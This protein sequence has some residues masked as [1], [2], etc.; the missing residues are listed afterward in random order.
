MYSTPCRGKWNSVGARLKTNRRKPGSGQ[1]AAGLRV[2]AAS[3]QVW[4][5][6]G[7]AQPIEQT[8]ERRMYSR[9][10]PRCNR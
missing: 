5:C 3:R 1:R 4:G 7:A 9:P 6:K 2:A 8:I 10:F